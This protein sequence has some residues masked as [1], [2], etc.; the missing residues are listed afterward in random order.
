MVRVG[1]VLLVLGAPAE[2]VRAPVGVAVRVGARERALV[3]RAALAG[4]VAGRCVGPL[5]RV[6]TSVCQ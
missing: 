3:R 5:L 1:V 2:V 4:R 6:V